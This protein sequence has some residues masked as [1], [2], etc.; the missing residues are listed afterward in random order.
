MLASIIFQRY[1]VLCRIQADVV[2]IGV[3]AAIAVRDAVIDSRFRSL[4]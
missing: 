4:L 3:I 1:G 2:H